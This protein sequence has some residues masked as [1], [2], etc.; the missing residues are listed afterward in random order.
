ML[1]KCLTV[2]R[3]SKLSTWTIQQ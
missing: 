1:F 3:T 2:I